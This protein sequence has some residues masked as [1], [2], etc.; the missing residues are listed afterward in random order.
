MRGGARIAFHRRFL[1][2]AAA[3]GRI[4]R[5]FALE[6]NFPLRIEIR[7]ALAAHPGGESFVQPEI[8]PPGHRHEIAEPLVGDLVRDDFVDALFRRSRRIRRIKQERRS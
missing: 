3:A 8:V 7:A 4:A 5:D 2:H 6:P 1:R